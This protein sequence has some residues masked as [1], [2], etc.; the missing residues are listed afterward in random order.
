MWTRSSPLG[1]QFLVD[2]RTGSQS[3][4]NNFVATTQHWTRYRKFR[5]F[6]INIVLSTSNRLLY[7][8][9]QFNDQDGGTESTFVE[10]RGVDV[11]TPNYFQ[12]HQKGIGDL[13]GRVHQEGNSDLQGRREREQINILPNPPT[14]SAA[15][16]LGTGHRHSRRESFM[17]GIVTPQGGERSGSNRYARTW[18]SV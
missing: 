12:V 1:S 3:S 10:R 16:S 2:V 18:E 8:N 15:L 4:Y 13:Q 6:N 9:L 5:V 7:N 17:G 14:S 11:N